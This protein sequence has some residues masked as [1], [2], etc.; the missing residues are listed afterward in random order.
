MI[1]AILA[2]QSS[3][4]A[5]SI[6]LHIESIR[7]PDFAQKAQIQGGVEVQ[8]TISGTCQVSSASARSGH[9]VLRRAA[10]ENARKWRFDTNSEERHTQVHYEFV[11]EEPKTDYKP[12]TKNMFDLPFAVRVISNMPSPQTDR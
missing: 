3:K 5:K 1:V 12:E 10:E 7:Y 11:L 9:P 6:A 8:I 2:G 4:E